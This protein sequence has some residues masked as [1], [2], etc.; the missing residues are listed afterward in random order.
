MKRREFLSGLAA[1]AAAS[2]LAR[3][4]HA[5][6]PPSPRRPNVL[7]IAS[8]DLNNSLGCYGHPTA[9][10]PHLDRLASR[11][12]RFDRAYCQFPLCN[13]S[14]ASLMT[15]RRPDTTRV[16]NNA[17]HFR[18][19]LPDVRTLPQLFQQ[20]GYFTARAG[21]MYHYGVPGQIGTDGLDD[22]PS[23]NVAINPLGR[24]KIEEEKVVH[25]TGG[26]GK[27][28]AAIAFLAA[29]GTDEEQTDGM[30]ATEIIKLLE[31]HR[32]GAFF[33]A[34]GFYRPHVPCVAPKKYF[35][36]HPR[37][38]LALPK[39][40]PDHLATVPAAALNIRPANYGLRDEQLLEFIQAYHASISFMDAQVGRLLD[41]LERLGLAENT[42]V[43]F[44][45]DNGYLL[46]E[47]GQWMKSSLFEPSAR[48]PMIIRAPGAKG[49]GVACPRTVEF[50]DLYP[51][52]ADLCGFAAPGAE[53]AS[54][55]PLL[56]NPTAEWRRPAYTQVARTMPAGKTESKK[57]ER[58]MGRSVRTERWRYTEWDGGRRGVQLYDHDKD[59]GEYR[60]LAEDPKYKD[61]V[62]RMKGLLAAVSPAE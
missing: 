18:E 3:A 59:P 11:G 27:L 48:V 53:G 14:R 31:A 51:T 58:Y 52:L 40:P 35:D 5:A 9:R 29:E 47:H 28:G 1:T 49:N 20:A 46:G 15:G 55:R 17:L 6:A 62:A 8:D 45:G 13:P 37:E 34:A 10:T 22:A 60:N 39:E 16:I 26:P 54:L 56:D 44:W 24:D 50:L 12:V 41:A 38:K 30:V 25:Y 2:S 19:A 7:F 23:W 43:V 57:P 61:V 42:I 21:K 4:A 33:L 32:D 36:L